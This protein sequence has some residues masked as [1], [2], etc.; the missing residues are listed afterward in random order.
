MPAEFYLDTIKYV[1]QEYSLAT[2]QWKFDGQ[3]VD[4]SAIT[5]VALFTI[6][7]ELDDISGQGQTRAAQQLCSAIPARLRKH[8]TAPS[9]GHYGIFSGRRWRQQICPKIQAFIRDLP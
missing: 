8:Y 1:F 6:E 5:S 2:H 4:P 7:G 3:L 9:C